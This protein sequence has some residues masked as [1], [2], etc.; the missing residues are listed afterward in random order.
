MLAA[1]FVVLVVIRVLLWC[2]EKALSK[3]A[4]AVLRNSG[5]HVDS[6]SIKHNNYFPYKVDEDEF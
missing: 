3:A 4:D 6:E 2:A 5:T 1:I